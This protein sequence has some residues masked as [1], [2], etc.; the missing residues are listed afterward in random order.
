MFFEKEKAFLKMHIDT[1]RI[2]LVTETKA[3]LEL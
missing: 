1:A 3:L 2:F